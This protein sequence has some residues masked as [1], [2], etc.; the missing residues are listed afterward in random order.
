[1]IDLRK[2]YISQAIYVVGYHQDK[3]IRYRQEEAESA[4]GSFFGSQSQQTNVPDDFDPSAPRLIFQ[5]SQKQL[6]LSQSAAQLVL[7]FEGSEKTLEHQSN[8]I[9]KNAIDLHGRINKFKAGNDL[10]ESALVFNINVPSAL[11]RED[12]SRNIYNRFIGV[13]PLGD[14][15]SVSFKVGFRTPSDLY[16]NYE[17]DVYELRK[18]DLANVGAQPQFFN[19][20][21]MPIVEMGYGLK[22]DINNKIKASN[23]GYVNEGPEQLIANM[24]EFI[25]NKLE[26]ILQLEAV[27]SGNAP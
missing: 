23:S 20:S 2:A 18:A 1:M 3:R 16:L 9:Y 14:I 6:M 22:V 25:A 26:G 10:L 21:E 15:A 5:A 12:L 11:G 7:G 27:A 17:V 13:E 4:F 19:I 8:I 24:K